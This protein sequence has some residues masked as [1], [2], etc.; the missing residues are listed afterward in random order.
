MIQA[1]D[2]D[3]HPRDPADRIWTE[4]TYVAF[5]VPEAGLHGTLYVLARPN[6]GVAMSSVVIARGVRRRPHEVDFCDPQIHLPCPASYSEFTLANGLSVQANSLTD[7]RFKYTHKLGACS[8]DLALRGLHHPFDP[9]DPREN[10][11]AAE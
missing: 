11:A 4:T 5:N 3:F 10:P 6:L 1:S 9:T 2:I 7:W 8:F